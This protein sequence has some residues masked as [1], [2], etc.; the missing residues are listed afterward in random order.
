M[1]QLDSAQASV[2][3]TCPSNRS[4]MNGP[5]LLAKAVQAVVENFNDQKQRQR[6]SRPYQL[7][8][9]NV[10]ML[11]FTEGIIGFK[12]IFNSPRAKGMLWQVTYNRIKSEMYIE[13][14]DKLKNDRIPVAIEGPS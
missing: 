5:L 9:S 4:N 7:T 11:W 13:V 14:F 2:P 12:A 3:A 10:R 6:G 1:N 8:P